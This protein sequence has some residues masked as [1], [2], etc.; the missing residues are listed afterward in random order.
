MKKLLLFVLL[1]SFSFGYGQNLSLSQLMS[2]RTMDLDDAET[3]LT[4]RGWSYKEGEEETDTTLGLVSF[5]YDTNGDFDYAQSF[6]VKMFSNYGTNRIT[7][8]IGKQPKYF[9]YLSAVKIFNPQLIYSGPVDGKLVKTYQGATT[10]FKFETVTVKTS[11]GND[12]TSWILRIY[13]NEDYWN[14]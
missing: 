6:L 11:F 7:I 1:T 14:L 13:S 4:Q 9:E 12:K 2:L 10:T 8:Q 5:V 3:Y